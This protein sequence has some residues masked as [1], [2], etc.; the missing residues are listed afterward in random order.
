MEKVEFPR[1]NREGFTNW[2]YKCE[3]FFKF[4]STPEEAKLQLVV[5]NLDGNALEW[6]LSISMK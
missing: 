6:Q 5:V 1:L 2:L 3:M 4:D